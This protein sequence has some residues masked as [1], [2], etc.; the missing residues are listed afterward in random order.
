MEAIDFENEPL[1]GIFALV[2]G[3]SGT[4]KTHLMATI[5][6][7]GKVL[8]VDADKGRRTIQRAEDL[9]IYWKNLEVVSFDKFADLEQLR[10]LCAANDPTQWSKAIG[11]EIKS[12]FDWIVIDTWTEIQWVMLQK[13]RN[14]QGLGGGANESLT[15]RKNIQIQHWGMMTDLNKLAVEAFKDISKDGLNIVFTMQEA[16]VKDEITGTMVKGPAIHGKLVKE[17]PAYFEIVVHTYNDIQGN[18]CATTLPKQGWPAKT[19]LGKG[20]E[21]KNPKAMEIF[22]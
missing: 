15:Y 22:Q 11:K 9:S 6:E 8:I 14:E 16:V 5:G 13:L 17:L 2:Y 4:G 21:Y 19:R 7:L 1:E 3:E 10:K 18:W 12:K 20:R